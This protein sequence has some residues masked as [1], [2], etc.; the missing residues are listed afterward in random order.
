M[1]I[2]SLSRV[3]R[4][5]IAF[6]VWAVL[7]LAL[8][9]DVGSAQISRLGE[10]ILPTAP[11]I[12]PH[13]R[14]PDIAYDSIHDVYLAVSGP[15]TIRGRF[16]RPDG[17]VAG[18]PFQIDTGGVDPQCASVAFNP[19]TGTFL[20]AWHDGRNAPPPNGYPD[21]F[22]RAL[23]Y[24]GG[25][26]TFLS[27]DT[28]LSDPG[29]G[30]WWEARAGIAYSTVSQ[31]FMVAW[32]Q[33]DDAEI[34]AR[35]VSANGAPLSPPFTVTQNT[36]SESRPAVTYNPATD[37]FLVG[38][39]GWTDNYNFAETR[40]VQAGAAGGPV[41]TPLRLLN[42]VSGIWAGDAAFNS[43]TGKSFF[44]FVHYGWPFGILGQR[45]NSDGTP[46]GTVFVVSS[47]YYAYD[48]VSVAYNPVSNTFALVTHI[49]VHPQDDPRNAEDA[50][51]ELHQDGT[52]VDNGIIATAIG[53]NG[54]FNPQ[55]AA[56]TNAAKWLL[57]TANLNPL[58]AGWS[59]FAQFVQTAT[60]ETGGPPPP[61]PPPS[62]AKSAPASGATGQPMSVTLSW[63][64][65]TGATDYQYC[66]NTTNDTACGGGW[67]SVGT[68]T[69]V[70]LP[71]LLAGVTYYWQ[72]QATVNGSPVAANNGTW[73]SLSTQV[74]IVANFTDFNNNGKS[75]L[76]WRNAQTGEIVVSLMDGTTLTGQLSLP[77][78]SET[79]WRIA[80][81]A[82]LNGDGEP[83]LVWR[84][85]LTG[86]IAVWFMNGATSVS[87]TRLPTVADSAWQIAA[88]GD[89]NGDRKPE[90]VWRHRTTGQNALWYL[91]YANNAL[92]VVGNWSLPSVSDPAWRIVGAA[93]FNHD[94]RGDLLWRNA[95][96]GSN[97]VWQMNDR[98]ILLN[99]ALPAVADRGWAVGAV[100]D[101]D[102]DGQADIVWRNCRTGWGAVWYMNGASAIDDRWLP[103]RSL[104]WD[105][106]GSSCDALSDFD[107]NGSPDIVWRNTSDGRNVI[108]H[109][110]AFTHLAG[111]SPLPQVDLSW[112]M[113]AV[114][115]FN[116]DGLPD[117]VWRNQTTGANVVWLMSGP[118]PVTAVDLPAVQNLPGQI[119]EI[120]AAADMDGDGK[121]DLIW[122]NTTTGAN[123]VWSMD[124]TTYLSPT[125]LPRVE[126]TAWRIVAAAD[127]DGDGKTDLVWHNGT[128][129]N[130]D[131]WFMNRT[132]VQ[133][134]VRLTMVPAD[135]QIIQAADVDRDG[136]ADLLWRNYATGENR[137]WFMQG[138]TKLSEVALPTE[139]NVDWKVLRSRH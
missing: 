127:F 21:L 123:V 10:T 45:Y 97:A 96:T 28:Q 4:S 69:S 105:L 6:A 137:I 138:A 128:T 74:P 25:V 39:D 49:S 86:E 8:S 18:D 122:R 58:V 61:P 15:G 91:S 88:I 46:D 57:V 83:D 71:N 115:D 47:Y 2:M 89:L 66:V 1:V 77:T 94:G 135:W 120:A 38:Y 132:A 27:T 116:A 104:Q 114:A 59:M 95:L 34:H 3:S 32:R 33:L 26:P 40:W 42:S 109:L 110:N 43:V 31:H 133:S 41:G 117:V 16:I 124:G 101:L 79:R 81:V 67:T 60:R 121:P 76:V 111:D 80:G 48:A 35:M 20:V 65:M 9:A 103:S 64:A 11:V 55:I 129:G 106:A 136:N 13:N 29:K 131:L 75:D 54:N 73:W 118:T 130:T 100:V 56:Q 70:S 52:P 22:V 82:D 126:N 30:S 23:M 36:Y 99:A 102:A 112:Q 139:P 51:V 113:T 50:V 90:F 78:V 119:W 7:A 63:T 68:A 12:P 17:T 19:T 14:Y 44:F 53:G 108:W 24:S 107:G 98:E 37:Q 72:A 134:V 93:D 84:H 125:L 92:T 85:T 62:L 87:E 5:A